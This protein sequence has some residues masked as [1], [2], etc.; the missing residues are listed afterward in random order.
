MQSVEDAFSNIC[1]LN[2]LVTELETAVDKLPN[3]PDN[4]KLKVITAAIS[5][6]LPVYTW[7]FD[8]AF[9]EAW[10]MTVKQVTITITSFFP[11][12]YLVNLAFV[13]SITMN[14]ADVIITYCASQ[15]NYEYVDDVRV[16]ACVQEQA[17]L[18]LTK[19]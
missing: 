14:Q 18:L 2:T 1:Y 5:S 11:Y 7:I 8:E 6:Y 19:E 16:D 13:G 17:A 4:E 12:L 10:D 3:H 15:Y 9:K